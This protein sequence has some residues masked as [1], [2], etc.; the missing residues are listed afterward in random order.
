MLDADYWL[1]KNYVASN[2]CINKNK[3][4]MHCNGKCYLAKQVAKATRQDQQSPESRKEKFEAQPFFLPG[5]ISLQYK[6]TLYKKIISYNNTGS[7]VK[8]Y[9]CSVFHP[10]SLQ[11]AS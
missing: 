10:P 11:F 6:L 7:P 5:D 9:Y 1:N 3:P 8:G 4:Q 2:L